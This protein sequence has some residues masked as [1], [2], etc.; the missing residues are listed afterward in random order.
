MATQ[1]LKN[2]FFDRKVLTNYKNYITP[3]G[4]TRLMDEFS[5]LINIERPKVTEIVSWAA[6]NGDRSE[7][8]DYIYGKKR[9]REIDK[10]IRFLTKRI[11]IAVIVNPVTP[12]VDTTQIFFGATVIFMESEG[13]KKKVSIVGVDEI[14]VAKNGISW[15]SPMA[16]ALIKSREG[17]TVYLHT[18]GGEKH[19][20]ILKVQYKKI[21]IEK[22][23]VS[24]K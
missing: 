2:N 8:G 19:I 18:P 10:R 15:L 7:N 3:D 6:G 16:K 24:N 13:K 4:Y 5:W 12:R 11:D 22:F 20:K 1:Q 9:L 17:D 21:F 23:D 14:N